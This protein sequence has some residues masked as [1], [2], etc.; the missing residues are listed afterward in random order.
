M[1]LPSLLVLL[2]LSSIS[3]AL[4]SQR[5]CVTSRR[6]VYRTGRTGIVRR[7]LSPSPS[8]RTYACGQDEKGNWD[9]GEISPAQN[10]VASER[11]DILNF[12]TSASIFAA[13][14][15]MNPAA[16][17]AIPFLGGGADD[18]R[19]LEYCLVNLLRVQYWAETVSASIGDSLANAP[20]GSTPSKASYVEARLGAKALLTSRVGGGA[21]ARVYG[22]ASLQIKGCLKDAQAWY[23]DSIKAASRSKGGGDKPTDRRRQ[24]ESAADDVV[25]SLAACVEFDG[26]DNTLDPSPRSSLMV[27]QYT[28]DKAT[29]VRRTLAE[30]TVPACEEFAGYFGTE[31][32][33][34]CELYVKETYPNE[35]P[36]LPAVPTPMPV[37]Q[38]DSYS[39]PPSS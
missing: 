23:G 7:T 10:S 39:S 38:R 29:F 27:S 9:Y 15:S 4:L 11:R 18:R 34:R 24:L 5:S 21:N 25:E 2:M 19:Q 6:H 35:V 13:A 16:A 12:L 31:V 33:G 1:F 3:E 17:E 36:R 30:R 28:S 22:L 26:L 37:E 14:A 32:R 20:P 8:D